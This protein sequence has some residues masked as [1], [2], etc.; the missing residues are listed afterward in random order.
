MTT[1]YVRPSGGA[2]GSEDGTAYAD[3]WDGLSNVVWGGAGVVGSDTLY[4]C[5]EHLPFQMDTFS[6][7]A[8]YLDIPDG[9]DGDH[10]IIRGDYA[11]DA[12]T[13]WGAYLFSYDSWTLD[14]TSTYSTTLVGSHYKDWYF[15]DVTT[16]SYTLLDCETSLAAC[17]ANAGSFYKDGQ[18]LWVHCSDNGDPT[19][20]ISCSRWGWWWA[21]GGKSYITVRDLTVKNFYR[22]QDPSGVTCHDITLQNLTVDYLEYYGFGFFGNC[23]NITIDNC[24]LQWGGNGVYFVHQN[25]DDAPYT[26]TVKDCTIHNIG[27]RAS[28]Y[29]GDAHGIGVQGGHDNLFENNHIYDAGTGITFFT[30]TDQEQKN[31]TIRYNFVK[32]THTNGGANSRGI[33][34]QVTN[35]GLSDKTGN[36]VHHNIVTNCS[37]F[38]YTSGVEDTTKFYNNVA[39]NCGTSFRHNR[40]YGGYGPDVKTRN[41]ISLSPTTLHIQF[42]TGQ[43]TYSCDFDYNLYY[44]DGATLFNYLGSISNF[45]DWKTNS[46]CDSNSPSIADPSFANAGGSYDLETDFEIA[47]GSPCIN[48]GVFP[49]NANGTGS[50]STTLIVDDSIHFYD[51]DEIQFEGQETTTVITDV[52]YDT[53]TITLTDVM[54]WAD[55]IGVSFAFNSTAPD[56][57]AEEYVGADV[58][59]EVSASVVSST[60]SLPTVT[61][62]T[63]SNI[64]ISAPVLSTVFFYQKLLFQENI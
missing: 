44:P 58:S 34:F 19:D 31:N 32:D 30:Y 28:Q 3:A 36:I 21:M 16:G 64:S 17:K 48:T 2:Y 5:G 37:G 39:H 1:W 20:R 33:E 8:G 40:G 45:A 26:S 9:S 24:T 50:N 42:T 29:N 15:E 4:I 43:P 27:T 35:D 60:M 22:F 6:T 53:N 23:Y 47:S 38:G 13:I 18:T 55:G 10:T 57:G 61:A 7:P 59:V 52:N 56:I 12:G 62:S 63:A 25:S 11:G 41:N 54:S 46:S 51:G 49:T 14:D